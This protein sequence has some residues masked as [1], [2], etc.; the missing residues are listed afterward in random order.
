MQCLRYQLPLIGISLTQNWNFDQESFIIIPL[1]YRCVPH[2][3]VEGLSVQHPEKAVSISYDIGSPGRVIE[4]SQLT[5]G[6]PSLIF[7]QEALLLTAREYFKATEHS[8]LDQKQLSP[9]LA[10]LDD[11]V[12]CLKLSLFHGIYHNLHFFLSEVSKHKA[13]FKPDLNLRSS[14][15]R[16][17]HHS[18]LKALLLVPLAKGLS[19]DRGPWS[20]ML[21][22]QDLGEL[23]D[24]ILIFIRKIFMLTTF[25]C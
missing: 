14:F 8:A 18:G 21:V 9:I 10:L 16:L 25:Q 5:E 11:M 17:L 7:P 23:F 13:F 12:P 24:V 22:R 20:F 4:Q 6:F 15:L 2:N 19:T 3:K 1:A